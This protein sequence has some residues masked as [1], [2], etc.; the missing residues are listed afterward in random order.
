MFHVDVLGHEKHFQVINTYEVLLEGPWN[1]EVK[2]FFPIRE[3][4]HCPF[5]L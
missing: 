3:P 1:S 4:T 2:F 5:T